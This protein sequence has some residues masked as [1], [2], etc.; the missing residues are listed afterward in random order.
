MCAFDLV[1]K[2]SM[3]TGIENEKDRHVHET[4]VNFV[5][6]EYVYMYIRTVFGWDFMH[7]TSA[8]YLFD[9]QHICNAVKKNEI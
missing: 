7:S 8:A 6:L 4:S 1:G 5:V 3:A 9:R 2:Q